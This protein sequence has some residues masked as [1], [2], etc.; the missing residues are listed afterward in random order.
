[1]SSDSLRLYVWR[2]SKRH[3]SWSA[4]DEPEICRESYH[5]AQVVVLARSEQEALQL[6]AEDGK[7]DATEIGRMTPTVVP[8]DKAQVVT[9]QIDPY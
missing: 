2:H 3:S 5:A 9:W 1:M 6:L 8:L 7:W 4:I